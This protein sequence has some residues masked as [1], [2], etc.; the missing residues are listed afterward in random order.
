MSKMEKLL[1]YGKWKCCTYDME[2]FDPTLTWIVGWQTKP[3]MVGPTLLDDVEA[4]SVM[5][6]KKEG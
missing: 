6:K 2:S 3:K 5:E 1:N 4:V